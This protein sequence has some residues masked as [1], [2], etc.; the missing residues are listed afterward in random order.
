[1]QRGLDAEA[2]SIDDATPEGYDAVVLGSAA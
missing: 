1:V 2:C